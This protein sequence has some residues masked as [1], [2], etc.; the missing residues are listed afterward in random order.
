MG[1]RKDNEQIIIDTNCGIMV[2][3]ELDSRVRTIL[4]RVLNRIR[5]TTEGEGLDMGNVKATYLYEKRGGKANPEG[6]VEGQQPHTDMPPNA[7][8]Q[9]QGRLPL[10]IVIPLSLSGADQHLW[11][12]RGLPIEITYCVGQVLEMS[13]DCVHGGGLCNDLAKKFPEENHGFC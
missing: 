1:V 9:A 11:D 10:S 2:L 13:H 7:S 8:V 12:G 6:E 3:R 5:I 4:E